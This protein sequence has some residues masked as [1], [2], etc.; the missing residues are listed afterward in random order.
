MLNKT[1]KRSPLPIDDEFE[2]CTFTHCDFSGMDLSNRKFIDCRFENC[3]LNNAT[4]L[5]TAFRNVAFVNCK[6]MGLFFEQC[7]IFG[8][9]MSFEE[10]ALDHSSFHGL[11]LPDTSFSGTRMIDVDLSKANLSACEF[12]ECDLLGA[13]FDDTN[14]ENTDLSSA[15]N[16]QLDP[17]SNRIKGT[18]FSLYALPGLLTKYDIEISD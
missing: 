7:N 12:K 4:L 2:N 18:K 3:D 17:D 11:N 9:E 13:M 14:I 15:V 5:D 6:M 8:L 16:M 1:I 10:C